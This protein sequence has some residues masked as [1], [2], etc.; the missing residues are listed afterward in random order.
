MIFLALISLTAC[1]G[2]KI[3][4][5]EEPLPEEVYSCAGLPDRPVAP[6]GQLEVRQFIYL[7]AYALYDCQDQLNNLKTMK[8]KK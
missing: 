2:I 4:D 3:A 7:T 6:Y 5:K 8:E 1:A